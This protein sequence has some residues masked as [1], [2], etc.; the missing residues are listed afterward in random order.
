MMSTEQP[1]LGTKGERELA[2]TESADKGTEKTASVPVGRIVGVMLLF[3]AVYGAYAVF[4]GIGKMQSSLAG[5]G[6]W[7]FGAACVLALGNYLL[8]YLKWEYYLKCLDVRGVSKV[9]SFFTFLSGFVLTVSPG[10]VGEV[11]KSLVLWETHKVPPART[12]PIVIA[13]RVTDL[14][15]VIILIA[16]G[17]LGLRGGL[18]WAGIGTVLVLSLL[19]VIA[20]RKL[21]LGIVSRIERMPG[22][23]GRL[24]PRLRDAY[25][26][27]AVLVRPTNL[28]W[29]TLLSIAAWFF[30]C[31]ALAVILRGFG[32]PVDVRLSTFFYATST[33]AGAIVPVPGGLGVTE[34]ALQQQMQ[35]IGGVSPESST[36]A[37]ML[38]RF[39]TLWFAVLVGFVALAI[40]RRRWPGLLSG[41]KK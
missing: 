8:R 32:E 20:S 3:V 29:P 40:L 12:A 10:K 41:E 9:D 25:E 4:R 27:L 34:T 17:S 18:L 36:A 22:R 31:L 35:E 28:V 15:G 21:S 7:A 16:A 39:A 5:F 33:L 37:M 13:E 6:W 23:L 24:G 1:A 30:E 19:V 14:I 26:S 38:V 2:P 11:F